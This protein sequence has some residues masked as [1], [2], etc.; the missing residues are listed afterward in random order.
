MRNNHDN[1]L[2]AKVRSTGETIQV[3]KLK[4]GRYNIYLGE[5]ITLEKIDN[6]EHMRV[7]EKDDLIL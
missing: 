7:F 6:K 2:N 4:D 3:F 1:I 5:N